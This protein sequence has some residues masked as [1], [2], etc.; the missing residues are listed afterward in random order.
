MAKEPKDLFE[1]CIERAYE[2]IPEA[3]RRKLKNVAILLEEEPTP[4]MR[5]QHKL[6]PHETLL[7][8]YQG[9]PLSERGASYGVG[10]TLPDTITLFRRPITEEAGG[11][12]RAL[13]R[14]IE[15]TLWHEVAHYLGMDEGEVRAREKKKK[16]SV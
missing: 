2:K 14:I 13:G 11:D 4:L 5:R 3:F 8:L 6:S 10:E 12:D 1:K 16:R 15:E 7:G 9:I